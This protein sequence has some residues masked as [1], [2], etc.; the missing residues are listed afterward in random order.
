[1]YQVT[2]N[3]FEFHLNAKTCALVH[4]APVSLLSADFG[5]SRFTPFGQGQVSARYL[6]EERPFSAA[7]E[8]SLISVGSQGKGWG[9][10]GAHLSAQDWS[11]RS[12]CAH[13]EVSR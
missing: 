8:G 9:G 1:M 7:L 2:T 5:P 10:C 13:N 11:N 12:C 6:M 4:S 3:S